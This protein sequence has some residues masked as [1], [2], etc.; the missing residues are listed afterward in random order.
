MSF[1]AVRSIPEHWSL[2]VSCLNISLRAELPK[3]PQHSN[4]TAFGSSSLSVEPCPRRPFWPCG[5][6]EKSSPEA[7]RTVCLLLLLHLFARGWDNRW[8]PPSGRPETSNNTVEVLGTGL[9]HDRQSASLNPKHQDFPAH[10]RLWN[11]LTPGKGCNLA[12]PADCQD[13]PSRSTPAKYL[14]A[15]VSGTTMSE[16]KYSASA[17][18]RTARKQLAGPILW[19]WHVAKS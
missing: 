13:V 6:P 11:H 12:H 16:A 14:G 8:A 4:S 15:K 7:R 1:E 2:N 9:A 19:H 10:V 18:M 17:C 5:G 3:C